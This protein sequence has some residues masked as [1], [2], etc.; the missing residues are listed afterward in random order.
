MES[1]PGARE[2]VCH[3]FA[4]SKRKLKQRGAGGFLFVQRCRLNNFIGR[5]NQM[6]SDSTTISGDMADAENIRVLVVEDE[7]HVRTSHK[8]R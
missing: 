7:S 6:G 5:M 3:P 2:Q 4:P 1:A 8:G